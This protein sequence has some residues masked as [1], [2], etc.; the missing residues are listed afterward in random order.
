MQQ[1]E[2][3]ATAA[4]MEEVFSELRRWVAEVVAP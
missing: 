2:R 4:A 1:L 3:P